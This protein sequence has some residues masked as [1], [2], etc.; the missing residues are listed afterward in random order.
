MILIQPDSPDVA[1]ISTERILSIIDK[2]ADSTAL[3]LLP[4]IQYYSGQLLDIETITKHAHSRHVP[5]GWD[6]AHAIGN[7]PLHLH[8]WDIDFAVWCHYKYLNSGAG[9]IAG[10]FVHSKHGQVDRTALEQG[11]NGFR[12]RLCGWWGG[13]K[14]I[15][16]QMAN[17]FLPIPGAQG[18][19]VGNASSLGVSALIASLEIF[20]LTDMSQLRKKS[21]A[22]TQYLQDLLCKDLDKSWQEGAPYRIITPLNPN[23][24]GAQLSVQ[25]QPGMLPIVME[26]LEEDCVILDERKPDVIRVAPAPLYN[27]F[28]DVWNFCQTFRKACSRAQVGTGASGSNKSVMNGHTH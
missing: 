7:V 21:L 6:L 22:L 25:L 26:A 8:D 2:N 17:K 1:T 28:Q 27:T 3:I 11:Q 16:F 24:R 9:S 5:I 19:Q 20:G 23:E 4:G 12:D 13:D 10:L 18:Y 15:R 14:S